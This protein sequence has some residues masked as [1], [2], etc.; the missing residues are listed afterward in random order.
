MTGYL[1]IR[2]STV[3]N[4][5]PFRRQVLR[6]LGDGVEELGTGSVWND[7]TRDWRA[8]GSTDWTP[9]HACL[10][11]ATAKNI[12]SL[13]ESERDLIINASGRFGDRQLRTYI[14]GW[15]RGAGV[16]T[17]PAQVPDGGGFRLAECLDAQNRPAVIEFSDQ[18]PQD[19]GMTP[20]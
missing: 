3:Q 15:L 18:A 19:R 1:Y 12:N 13:E 9:L 10:L 20:V 8:W 4:L 11:G 14:A 16:L 2:E 5:S 6:V 7:G 17:L